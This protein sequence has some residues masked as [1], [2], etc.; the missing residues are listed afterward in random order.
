VVV[1]DGPDRARLA[2]M[3]HGDVRFVGRI[4]DDELR[5]WYRTARVV[6]SL[7]EHEAFGLTAAEAVVAGARVVL[8]DIPAHAELGRGS[9]VSAGA[10]DAEVAAVLTQALRDS[11]PGPGAEG[12]A[13]WDDVA[14]QLV[15]LYDEARCLT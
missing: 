7:S 9:L 8:S 4:G 14:G 15:A 6:C 3:A 5:R 1:G 10:D 13:S 11:G 12:I 2:A